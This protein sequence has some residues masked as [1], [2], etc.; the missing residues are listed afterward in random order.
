MAVVVGRIFEIH[1]I[2]DK[3]AQVIIRKKDRDKIIY[4]AYGVF[5]FWKDK[6][7]ELNL[8][9]KDK[10]KANV[11]IKSNFFKEK[12]RWYTDVFFRDVYVVEIA[13]IKMKTS[14][15][16]DGIEGKVDIETGEV[17]PKN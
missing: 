6:L 5:G 9:P 2:S 8:K 11:H 15:L 10:I 17:F 1:I 13:P 4:Q 14:G 12:N 3:V 16:F 7:M